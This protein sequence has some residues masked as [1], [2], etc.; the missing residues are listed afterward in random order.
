MKLL[1][2]LSLLF[3]SSAFAISHQATNEEIAD[4]IAHNASLRAQGLLA[5]GQESLVLR[6]VEEYADFG[7]VLLSAETSSLS[8][9]AELRKIIAKNLPEH[10]KLVILTSEGEATRTRATYEQW[11][12]RDR[13]IIAVHPT[14]RNGFW[15]RDSFPVPVVM[16]QQNN[17]GLV[18]ARYFRNFEGHQAISETVKN[19]NLMNKSFRFVGGN[20]LADHE[21]NC[22][23]V[24]STRM[25]GLTR[26][27]ILQNYGCASLEM[28]PHEAGIGDVDEV[29][30]PLPG[31]RMLTNESSYVP[32]LRELG[33]EVIMLPDLEER[34]RTYVNALVVGN[35]VFMP[36]YGVEEDAE[37]T[38]VY[39]QLGYQVVPIRSNTLS[40]SYLGSIHCQTMAYPKMDLESFFRLTG[41][42]KL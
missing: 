10:V 35:R 6:P 30:K 28:L 18:A 39:E 15:A 36:T 2:A 27:D 25:F 34:Y 40:D 24:D 33:Y 21:G 1:L 23:V 31:K 17:L 9:A 22:F 32:R 19:K 11:I 16:K 37:A 41:L 14:Y 5:G 3:S 8:E 38:R 7:Y 12:P 29:I 42:K 4:A 13:L 26:E 20:L